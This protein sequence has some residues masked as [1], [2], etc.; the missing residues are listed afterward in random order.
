MT[1]RRAR[2]AQR[3]A[4]DAV[5]VLPVSYWKLSDREIFKFFLSMA[6]PSAFPTCVQQPDY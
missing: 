4:A 3:A 6:M 2:Y 1:T 5:M